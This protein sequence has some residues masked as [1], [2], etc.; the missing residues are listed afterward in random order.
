MTPEEAAKI[1]K[2]GGDPKKVEEF[3]TTASARD[4]Q[5]FMHSVVAWSRDNPHWFLMARPA[6]DI[7][8]A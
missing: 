3:L 5:R 1:P 8:I 7:W 2:S 4:L 6:L